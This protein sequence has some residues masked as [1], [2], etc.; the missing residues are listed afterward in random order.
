MTTPPA[1]RRTGY[2]RAVWPGRL[3]LVRAGGR[4]VLLDGAHNP[5]GA[6]ALAEAVGDLRPFLEAGRVTL[7]LGAMA[8]KDVDGII[9]ALAREPSLATARV[10]ATAVD[11]PRALPAAMLAERWRAL[12]PDG[13]VEAIAT[14]EAALE[15]ALGGVARCGS[16]GPI[17]VA[18][19]LYLVGEVRARLVD[20]PAA[21]RR[22]MAP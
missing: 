10:L 11:A 16:P 19:S 20:D 2:G 1:A 13:A 8:D 3:E 9:A 5:A 17:V 21:A 12:L 7:V 22:M 15:R 14:P 18:G 6:A 4:D